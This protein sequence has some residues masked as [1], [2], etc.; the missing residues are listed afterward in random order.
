MFEEIKA[1]NGTTIA[2]KCLVCL[3]EYPYKVDQGTRTL[4]KH[5]TTHDKKGETVPENR[6]TAMVQTQLGVREGYLKYDPDKVRNFFIKYCVRIE[7]PLSMTCD[8]LF[9]E[10]I[11]ESL[12]PQFRKSY[13]KKIND[14]LFNIFWTKRSELYDEFRSA[15]YKVSITSDIW[16]AGKHNMSY[17]SVTAHWITQDT[18]FGTCDKPHLYIIFN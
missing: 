10:F 5:K 6:R 1:L 2:A 7:K 13:H 16:S 17:S 12:H 15:N 3:K 18:N 14:D 4:L 11:K 8:P 9:E